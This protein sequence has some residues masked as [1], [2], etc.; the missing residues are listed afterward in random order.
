LLNRA[1]LLGVLG[2]A[3]SGRGKGDR[4]QRSSL[5][6]SDD[7]EGGRSRGRGRGKGQGTNRLSSDERLLLAYDHADACAKVSLAHRRT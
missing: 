2:L 1:G 3:G 7:A 6:C 5:L 4:S